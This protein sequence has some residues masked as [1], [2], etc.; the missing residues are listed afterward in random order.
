MFCVNSESSFQKVTLG[1]A[2]RGE[3]QSL[4]SQKLAWHF[5]LPR[6]QEPVTCH[7]GEKSQFP[8]NGL[9]P[10]RNQDGASQ[11]QVQGG[12]IP[13]AAP[14]GVLVCW[15]GGGRLG[16]VTQD[17]HLTPLGL[18]TRLKTPPLRTAWKVLD[19]YVVFQSGR[20]SKCFI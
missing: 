15:V 20:A 14:T 18:S 6:T 9:T 16:E 17:P 1:L 8:T 10:K 2:R 19:G 12:L 5:S 7:V 13:V 11:L 3:P 4:W